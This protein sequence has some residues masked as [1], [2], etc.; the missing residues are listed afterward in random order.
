MHMRVRMWLT[1]RRS[2]RMLVAM[3]LVVP[4]KVIVLECFMRVLV[5]VAFS[6][7]EPHAE[8]HQGAR[9]REPC[10]QRLAEHEHSS[11]CAD[12]GGRREVRRG[13]GRTQPS[14]RLHEKHEARAVTE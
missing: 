13:P 10:G 12:E 11:H 4:V 14:Q 2:C 5:L 3:M 8:S 6:E 1:G 7:V 9:R